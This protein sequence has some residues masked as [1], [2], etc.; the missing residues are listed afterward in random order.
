[1]KTVLT[2]KEAVLG[3]EGIQLCILGQVSY[4]LL[5]FL[6]RRNEAGDSPSFIAGFDF[7]FL[8]SEG[9]AWA[10]ACVSW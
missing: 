3:A 5:L 9:E 10:L 8:S 7:G 1:M 4:I 2:E 6:A